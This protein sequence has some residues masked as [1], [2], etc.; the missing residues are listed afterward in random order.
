MTTIEALLQKDLKKNIKDVIQVG[1]DDEDTVYSEIT[2]YVATESIQRQY[3]KLLKGIADSKSDP[4]ENI[5]V[6]ISGFFGSGKSSFAKNLGYI[7]QNAQIRGEMASTLFKAQIEDARVAQFLDVINTQIPIHVIMFDVSASNTIRTP[8]ESIAHIM[9]RQLLTQLGYASD[10]EIAELEIELE[11]ENR[12][13]Q[14]MQICEQM[15]QKSWEVVRRNVMTGYSRASAILHEIDPQTY[16]QPD[17]WAALLKS[18]ETDLTV[19]Q[20]V[21]RAFVLS[22][23]RRPGKATVFIIDEVGRYVAHSNDKLEILRAV[24]EQFGKVGKRLSQQNKIIAPAWIVVTSQEKLGEV[25]DALD[26]TRI[27]LSKVKDRFPWQV[28]LE[29][30]DIREVAT[31]RVLAK[32]S[33]GTEILRRLYREHEGQL[34]AACYLEQSSTDTRVT[35][36]EFIQFYPYL[37]HFIDMSIDIMS[38]IRLQPGAPPHLGGSN[39]TIIKQVYEMLVTAGLATAPVGTLVTL[40]KIYELVSSSLSDER[41][42]D[43]DRIHQ[44]FRNTDP[45]ILRVAKALALLEF[46]TRTPRTIRNI[47]ALLVS[48]VGQAA[49][50]NEVEAVLKKL[51]EFGYV[52]ET[53]NGW[54]LQT[55]QERSWETERREFSPR[56]GDRQQILRDALK[57]LFDDAQMLTLRYKNLRTFR[58]GVSL[59]G[60]IISDEQLMLHVYSANTPLDFAAR[61]EEVIAESRKNE[62]T[63]YW[64]FAISPDI[65]KLVVEIYASDS[66]TSKYG[67]MIG[68]NQISNEQH[69]NLER[70]RNLKGVYETRLREA[71]KNAIEAGSSVF[72]GVKRDGSRYAKT[73]QDIVKNYLR[74]AVPM[75]Y[76]NLEI[77]ARALPANASEQMLRTTNLRD[78]PNVFH[79]R[80]DGLA[81]V[82]REGAD[83]KPNPEAQVVQEIYKYLT[84]YDEYGENERLTGA[85]LQ[86]TF[87]GIG[88]GWESDLI[89]LVLSFLFRADMINVSYKGTIF[90]DYRN[91][92]SWKV[93]T[94]PPAFRQARFIPKKPID[95]KDRVTAAQI[96]ERLTGE[97]VDLQPNDISA[98][99]QRFANA[100][101]NNVEKMILLAQQHRLPFIEYLR[102]YESTLGSILQNSPEDNVYFLVNDGDDIEARKGHVR[103]IQDALSENS[104]RALDYIRRVMNQMWPEIQDRADNGTLESA[105]RINEVLPAATYYEYLNELIGSADQIASVYYSYYEELH[106]QRGELFARAVEEIISAEAW[107][108]I[109]EEQQEQ[110]LRPLKEKAVTTTVIDRENGELVSRNTRSTMREMASDINAVS[111]LKSNVIERLQRILTPEKPIERVQLTRF[112]PS[113]IESEEDIAQAIASL[114]ERLK[115]LIGKGVKVIVE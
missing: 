53:E 110:L 60:R 41:R 92:T 19:E 26:Q 9:Y 109:T 63:P 50:T 30:S 102:D 59:D 101:K 35:E 25:V 82:V 22:Q 75:I 74:E 114:E 54:K 80:D 16:P 91:D 24:V 17:T 72:N 84:H 8:D 47:A 96:Y 37:P 95:R 55:A 39:R 62:N 58:L 42:K 7:L 113:T 40:D 79:E 107:G 21:E 5:G 12:L 34:N 51:A 49:P 18:R 46:V 78:L 20:F 66:M 52:R 77:G 4:S 61:V 27:E 57:Q 31:R 70:E 85:E 15:Y 69:A 94:S 71:L 97:E 64:V 88:Y 3:R 68:K 111:M 44:D 115:A 36:D 32:N 104:L 67:R 1:Q 2:E 65:D 87:T 14:F 10:Y 112:F 33:E 108:Q 28:D 45:M 83:Y 76:P 56:M 38:G 89:Q 98:A 43:M 81:L 6:W 99:L 93:F 86:R 105:D 11:G 48:N 13:T 103:E 100:E 106:Q 29:P 23:R 73:M 90:K